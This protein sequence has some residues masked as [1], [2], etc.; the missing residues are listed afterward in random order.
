MS[1]LSDI[2]ACARLA[3]APALGTLL[4]GYFAYHMIQGDHGLLAYLQLSAQLRA[5]QIVHAE[6]RATRDRL[7]HRVSLLRP[8]NL[9]PDMLEERA[10]VMLG[11]GHRDEVV[12][13]G[14]SLR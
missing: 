1:V 4:F 2:R 5:A 3:V 7:A 6:T 11:V 12:I 9:D 14:S 13:L 8:D 10:R